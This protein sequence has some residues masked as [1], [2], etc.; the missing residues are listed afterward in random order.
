MRGHGRAGTASGDVW[1]ALKE[2]NE[3]HFGSTPPSRGRDIAHDIDVSPAEATDGAIIPLRI[4]A[5]NACPAC[6]TRTDEK[7]ARACTTRKGEGRIIREQHT[8]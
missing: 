1:A 8:Y 5:H 3:R 6:A 4:T 2:V 7:A